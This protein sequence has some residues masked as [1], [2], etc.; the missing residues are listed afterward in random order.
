MSLIVDEG[1]V[2]E[3]NTVDNKSTIP[4]NIIFNNTH[5]HTSEYP[6]YIEPFDPFDPFDP[7]IPFEP[8]KHNN[9]NN[10]HNIKPV[11]GMSLIVDEGGVNENNTVDN[12]LIPTENTTISDNATY[13]CNVMDD[14]YDGWDYTPDFTPFI[15]PKFH[16]YFYPYWLP[17][18]LLHWVTGTGI[19][20][21][22][23]ENL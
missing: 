12:E 7:F 17:Y 1:G 6:P 16:P 19:S 9:T 2:N 14:N 18:D 21:I 15:N 13:V 23:N 4:N 22:I 10:N 5:V 8:F 20:T 3:N 11:H